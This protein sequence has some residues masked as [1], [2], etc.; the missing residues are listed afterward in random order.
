MRQLN[1]ASMSR[2]YVFRLVYLDVYFSVANIVLIISLQFE[3]S[4]CLHTHLCCL[5]VLFHLFLSSYK[6][7]FA[8]TSLIWLLF[9]LLLLDLVVYY[10]Q[11]DTVGHTAGPLSKE[12]LLEALPQLDQVLFHLLQQITASPRG[13]HLVLTSD[14]GMA[15]VRGQELLDRFI[16]R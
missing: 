5:S 9:N 4:R 12:L 1:S 16:S 3:K 7:G 8:L 15:K 14:H 2:M 13:V 11:L 6:I 10:D